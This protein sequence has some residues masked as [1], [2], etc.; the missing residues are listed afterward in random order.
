MA[1]ATPT[2]LERYLRHG[3][4]RKAL[5]VANERAVVEEQGKTAASFGYAPLE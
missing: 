3:Q 1:A 2:Q 5:L 4:R